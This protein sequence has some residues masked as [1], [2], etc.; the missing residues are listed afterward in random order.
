MRK[1]QQKEG[2]HQQSE[3]QDTEKGEKTI[4]RMLLGLIKGTALCEAGAYLLD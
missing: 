4:S 2:S 1:N 3:W